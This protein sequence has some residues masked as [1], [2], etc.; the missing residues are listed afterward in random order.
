MGVLSPVVHGVRTVLLPHM[1]LHVIAMQRATAVGADA[2][3]GQQPAVIAE[4]IYTLAAGIGSQ[5]IYIAEAATGVRF[6][7]RVATGAV[8]G[9]DLLAQLHRSGP[10]FLIELFH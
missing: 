10:E 1:A 6:L 8:V 4:E 9:E 2:A 5:E 7:A 3:G